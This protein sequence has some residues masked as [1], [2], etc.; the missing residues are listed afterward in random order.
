MAGSPM[1]PAELSRE[2]DA[3]CVSIPPAFCLCELRSKHWSLQL[4]GITSALR[5]GGGRAPR[6]VPAPRPRGGRPPLPGTLSPCAEAFG[7][8]VRPARS[9]AGTCFTQVYRFQP[10]LI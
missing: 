1:Q 7:R 8:R 5:A 10:S 9:T 4:C 2:A 6:R 3:G